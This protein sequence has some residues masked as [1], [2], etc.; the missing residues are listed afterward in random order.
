LLDVALTE[1][2]QPEGETFLIFLQYQELTQNHICLEAKIQ[3]QSS[4]GMNLDDV[5]LRIVHDSTQPYEIDTQQHMR[6]DDFSK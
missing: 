5:K 1:L 3:D 6:E 4:R 2:F